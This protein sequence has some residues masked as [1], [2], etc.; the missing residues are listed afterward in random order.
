METGVD[1]PSLESFADELDA[2]MSVW[3]GQDMR[4]RRE[5][6]ISGK[7]PNHSVNDFPLLIWC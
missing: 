2:Q 6:G 5:K 3:A 4:I 1:D 7:I